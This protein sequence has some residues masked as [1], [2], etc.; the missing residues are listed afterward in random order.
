M[1][2]KNKNWSCFQ[3]H[4]SYLF[5]KF[6]WKK[7]IFND[8][9]L[10]THEFLWFLHHQI[11]FPYLGLF[12]ESVSFKSSTTTVRSSKPATAGNRKQNRFHPK[13]RQN[14]DCPNHSANANVI[15]LLR[16]KFSESSNISWLCF[17]F[18]KKILFI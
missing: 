13:L 4:V 9:L 15:N 1:L 10:W 3:R 11:Q 18:S 7:A 5:V 6:V 16:A 17:F 2:T 14:P 8:K 12:L